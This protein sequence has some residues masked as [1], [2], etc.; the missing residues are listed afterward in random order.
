MI[1]KWLYGKRYDKITS[2]LGGFHT[3]NVMLKILYKKYALLG[4]KDWWIDADAIAMGS[5]DQCAE[6]RHYSRSIRLHKQSYEALMRYRIEEFALFSAMDEKLRKQIEILRR[7][8]S[9]ENLNTVIEM[10]EFDTIYMKLLETTGT[11]SQMMVQYMCDVSNLLALVSSV[12]E[13][14]IW[15]HIQAERALLPKLFAFGHPNY[16]RYLTYQHV[17]LQMLEKTNPEAWESLVEEGFGASRT[18]NP[19]SAIHGDLMIETTINREVKVRGGPMQGGYS[20]NIE[21]MNKFVKTSHLMAKVRSTFNEKLHQLTTSVHKET[22]PG[23]KKE[24]ERVVIRLVDALRNLMDPFLPGMDARNMKSGEILDKQIIAGLL[25]SDQ[26]GERCL[27]KFIRERIKE[28][29]VKRVSFFAPIKNPKIDTGLRKDK[30]VATAV[31]ILKEE[32]QAF[33]L[34]V[35]KLNSTEEALQYPLTSIPLS[36]ATPDGNLRQSSNASFRNHIM[37]KGINLFVLINLFF[38][39]S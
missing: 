12:R 8:I 16:S 24:H 2:L 1:I 13:H 25:H 34:L 22:T 38:F 6:G 32:K 30:K 36:L 23:S 9:P 29:G 4:L 37:Q 28:E 18:A 21:S 39:L 15:R 10:E 11:Q 31:N 17:M 5:A 20:T 33:G 27:S 19:F 7:N 35:G 3:L 26:T 14:D